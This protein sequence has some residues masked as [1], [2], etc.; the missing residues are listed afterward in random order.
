MSADT[1]LQVDMVDDEI[2]IRIGVDAIEIAALGAPVL[3]GIEAFRITDK[4]AFARAVLAELSRELGDD[5]TT[6][7]HKMFDAAFLAAVEGGAD[8]CDL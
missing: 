2:V 3:R 5:G 1:F 6:H 4:R 7:V 8:G